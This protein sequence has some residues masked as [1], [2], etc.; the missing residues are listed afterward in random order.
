M[1]LVHLFEKLH[2]FIIND[3]DNNWDDKSLL[4]FLYPINNERTF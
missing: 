3:N 4:T 1:P 2:I